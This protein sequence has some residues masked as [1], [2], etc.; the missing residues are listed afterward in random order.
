MSL[1]CRLKLTMEPRT[2]GA[3]QFGIETDSIG[4]PSIHSMPICAS[5][6]PIQTCPLQAADFSS[7]T[8]FCNSMPKPEYSESFSGLLLAAG[9]QCV[10]KLFAGHLCHFFRSVANT[11]AMKGKFL[12]AC[13]ECVGLLRNNGLNAMVCL[14][15]ACSKKCTSLHPGTWNEPH[16]RPTVPGSICVWSWVNADKLVTIEFDL[17][18]IL[19][20]FPWIRVLVQRSQRACRADKGAVDSQ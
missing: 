16:C 5:F 17:K 3:H 18:K 10:F 11:T 14:L 9:V 20:S 7:Q 6:S 19:L 12:R 1:M 4:R 2:R 13:W 8:K 15:L